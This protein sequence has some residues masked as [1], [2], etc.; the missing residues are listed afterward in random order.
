MSDEAAPKKKLSGLQMPLD[1]SPA[2]ARV[3]GTKKGEQVNRAQ[4]MKKLWAYLKEKNLQVS[5]ICLA[6]VRLQ[7][8]FSVFMM[9]SVPVT[10]QPLAQDPE[11]KQ[12]LT[13]DTLMEP[14]FGGERI[15]AFGMAKYLKEHLT[16]PNK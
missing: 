13:P 3:I 15:K 16:N 10:L 14:V 4:V 5:G 2:L 12:W 8:P 11:N 6:Y 9:Q 1:V 7:H